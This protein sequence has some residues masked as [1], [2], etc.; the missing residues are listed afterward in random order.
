M[1]LESLAGI[2]Y[3]DLVAM[4][5]QAVDQAVATLPVD[6]QSRFS[7][8]HTG[9]LPLLADA[10]PA[11]MRDLVVSF[12]ASF[13]L[14]T[15]TLSLGLRS[16]RLGFLSMLPNVFPIITVF[17][18]MGWIRPTIDPGTMMT[19][20]IGL[21]I[22]V[23]DTVHFLTWFQRGRTE[24]LTPHAAVR[25]A[26]QHCGKAILRTTIIC[27]AGLAVYGISSFAPAARF[28][29]LVSLLLAAAVIGDLVFLPALLSGPLGRLI[30][31]RQ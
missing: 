5:E 16:L 28:G 12:S 11:L 22:A 30:S 23:D 17:G 27:G 9:M 1:R 25:H 18:I 4:L 31:P 6:E 10:H 21:G 15:I 19:A 20:S 26:Y 13:I 8:V 7:V 3:E 14:I 2:R 29:I 24:G